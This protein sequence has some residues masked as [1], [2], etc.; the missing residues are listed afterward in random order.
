MKRKQ[1]ILPLIVLFLH[2]R[3]SP[4]TARTNLL[5]LTRAAH[6]NTGTMI[7]TALSSDSTT[8]SGMNAWSM[9]QWT[10]E[11][12]ASNTKPTM[13]LIGTSAAIIAAL[14]SCRW[15][16]IPFSSATITSKVY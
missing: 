10:T 4:A 8:V 7:E 13:I 11:L 2:L 9:R 5:A 15:P 14:H 12:T 6:S 1:Q 3:W 16:M